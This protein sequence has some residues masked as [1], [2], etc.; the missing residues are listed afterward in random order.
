MSDNK[1]R[2]ERCRREAEGFLRCAK[3]PDVQK[4]EAAR[5][6][7]EAYRL[8]AKA[9]DLMRAHSGRRKAL[10]TPRI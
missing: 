1:A 3:H 4:E 2:A 5:L 6:T 8:L 7:A 10:P 9:A